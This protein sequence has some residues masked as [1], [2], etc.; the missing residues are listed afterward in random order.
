M[1]IFHCYKSAHVVSVLLCVE[2][3]YLKLECEMKK[4]SF[5]FYA[6]IRNDKKILRCTSRVHTP[7]AYCHLS[8]PNLVHMH[9]A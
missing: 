5:P 2:K 1:E 9:A 8:L 4:W 6:A 3:L 7:K